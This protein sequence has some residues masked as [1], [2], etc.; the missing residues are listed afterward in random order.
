MR[1]RDLV[2][3]GGAVSSTIT[4]ATRATIT[5]QTT[6]PTVTGRLKSTTAAAIKAMAT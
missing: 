5:V 6:A 2:G 1:R 3:R 4:T